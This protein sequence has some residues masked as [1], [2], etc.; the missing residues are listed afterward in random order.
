[1]HGAGIKGRGREGEATLVQLVHDSVDATTALGD[2]DHVVFVD[3]DNLVHQTHIEHDPTIPSDIVPPDAGTTTARRYRSIG[4]IRQFNDFG[5]LLCEPGQNSH[6]RSAVQ[7]VRTRAGYIL[8]S[9]YICS[10]RTDILWPYNSLYPLD[11]HVIHTRFNLQ[12]SDSHRLVAL[13]LGHPF[14]EERPDALLCVCRFKHLV[15]KRPLPDA[16]PPEDPCQNPHPQ[17][18]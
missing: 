3:L 18:S 17:P 4:L 9:F 6:L 13:E 15:K 2:H 16:G 5:N 1:M 11:Y 14:F 10:G 8:I 7:V 12:T